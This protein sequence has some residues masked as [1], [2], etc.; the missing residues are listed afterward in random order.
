[1]SQETA[2]SLQLAPAG[3]TISLAIEG[4]FGHERVPISE[5]TGVILCGGLGSRIADVTMDKIAKPTLSLKGARAL[6]DNPL[7]FMRRAGVRQIY[8]LTSDQ[9]IDS[10][11]HHANGNSNF[12]G[13]SYFVDKA[14]RG[15]VPALQ[16]FIRETRIQTPI[17]KANGD[18]VFESADLEAMYKEHAKNFHPIT[19]LVTDKSMG[20]QRY[21]LSIG[22]D[23]RIVAFEEAPFISA[24]KKYFET[25]LWIFEPTQ[26]GFLLEVSNWREFL[27]RSIKFGL[28][29]AFKTHT[30]FINVNTPSDL[31]KARELTSKSTQ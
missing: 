8:I 12:D 18:E 26:F 1:M 2:R 20:T 24:N 13:V 31:E 28:A 30:G 5:A 15:T 6:I 4:G 9:G 10:L 27:R 16:T 17:V 25:G 21:R 7:S 11:R 3:S 19:V 23:E 29:Y 14:G 22:H